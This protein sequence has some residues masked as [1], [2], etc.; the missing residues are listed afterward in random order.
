METNIVSV[1]L[2]PVQEDLELKMSPLSS[3]TLYFHSKN[4]LKTNYL[5]Y[6]ELP[7]REEV[8]RS[9]GQTAFLLISLHRNYLFFVPWARK[10]HQ[11]NAILR[12]TWVTKAL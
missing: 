3:D 2:P 12:F 9:S 7:A 11:K 10:K 6:S 8:I 1:F 4:I 5:I